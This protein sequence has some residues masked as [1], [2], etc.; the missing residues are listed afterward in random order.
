MAPPDGVIHDA[1]GTEL[2]EGD[3]EYMRLYGEAVAALTGKAIAAAKPIALTPFKSLRRDVYLPVKNSYYRGGFAAGI[4]EREAFV[5]S[6]DPSVA[7]QPFKL[8][9][10]FK[11]MAIRTEINLLRLGTLDIIGIPGEIYPEL[12]YGKFQEP[13]DPAVD[14]PDAPLEKTVNDIFSERTW[15]LIG[16]ANDEVGYIIPKR[17]WDD[18]KPYA[19]DRNKSQYG[20]MNSCSPDVAPILME[21]LEQTAQLLDANPLRIVSHNVWYGFKKK[22]QRKATWLKWMAG[23]KP[24]IVALQELNGYTPEKLQQDASA[25]GHSHSALLKQDGFPTGL[26][27]R[28]PITEERR[29]KEGFHHGLLR[30]KTAGLIIYVIH[31][32]PSDWEFRTREAALLLADIA[33]LPEED[34]GKVILIGDFNGFSPKEKVHLEK[35][36]ELVGFFQMLDARDGSNNLNAGKL[37]YAGIQAFHDAGHADLVHQHRKFGAP[38]PGTFPTELRLEEELGRDRRLDYAFVPDALAGKVIEAKVLR[39]ETTASLSDHYPLLIEIAQN[40][41][42]ANK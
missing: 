21:A 16:L 15:M 31:F 8:T 10:T 19:Y 14:F 13:A 27:S 29:I 1:N 40:K 18:D 38:Y 25:W 34:Q 33:T 32:H 12:V 4:L 37:D 36:Q 22:E 42:A 28:F 20:E 23:Q 5:D 41:P 39:D 24:D 17:Q 7:G 35:D 9:D 6:G 26:T 2:E 3:F 11:T 30:C